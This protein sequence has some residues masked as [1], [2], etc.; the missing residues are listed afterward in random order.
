MPFWRQEIF[1]ATGKQ[2]MDEEN[3]F[4]SNLFFKKKI[5]VQQQI[6]IKL[7]LKIILQFANSIYINQLRKNKI[8]VK[9]ANLK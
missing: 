7:I 2:Q 3:N 8:G 9:N 5:C 6:K 1:L 4:Q